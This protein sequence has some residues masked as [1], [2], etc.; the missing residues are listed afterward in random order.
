MASIGVLTLDQRLAYL[1]A[2]VPLR[3]VVLISLVAWLRGILDL[4][5]MSPESVTSSCQGERLQKT[6]PQP[7]PG[8]MR[9]AQRG[10]HAQMADACS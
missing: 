8:P 3:E 9:V 6:A 7:L 5:D 1:T 10:Y 4:R 2:W